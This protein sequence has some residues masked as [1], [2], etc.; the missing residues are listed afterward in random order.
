MACMQRNRTST[1]LRRKFQTS[2]EPISLCASEECVHAGGEA[3][4]EEVWGAARGVL[5]AMRLLLDASSTACLPSSQSSGLPFLAHK[6]VAS[7]PIKPDSSL[8]T[9]V[10]EHSKAS[11]FPQEFH[12]NRQ[13]KFAMSLN[14]GHCHCPTVCH[15]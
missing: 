9:T 11:L 6:N 13:I 12:M 8:C 7:P 2:H 15:A 4:P 14:C 5:P 3:T 10:Y 1:R